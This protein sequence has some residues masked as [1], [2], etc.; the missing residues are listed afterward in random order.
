MHKE[1]LMTDSNLNIHCNY[2]YY[3]E[4]FSCMFTLTKSF[5]LKFECFPIF[6]YKALLFKEHYIA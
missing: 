1:I 3:K 2:N 6:V 4:F 5:T